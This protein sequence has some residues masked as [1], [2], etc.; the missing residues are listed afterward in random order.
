MTGTEIIAECDVI[1]GQRGVGDIGPDNW[2]T[3]INS[4]ILYMSTALCVHEHLKIDFSVPANETEVSMAAFAENSKFVSFTDPWGNEG[5]IYPP[6]TK[7]PL[8]RIRPQDLAYQHLAGHTTHKVYFARGNILYIFPAISSE[9]L[10][11]MLYYARATKL[12]D[13]GNTP[14]FDNEAYHFALVDYAL[15]KAFAS[16]VTEGTR[17]ADSKFHYD[18]FYQQVI[19]IK[20]G[21][22]SQPVGRAGEQK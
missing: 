1:F 12:A 9:K 20:T 21:K 3:W 7:E 11:N 22:S 8:V 4:G 6:G 13:E 14:I 19:D 2:L 17:L 18:K 16:K 15:S 5:T 10:Y